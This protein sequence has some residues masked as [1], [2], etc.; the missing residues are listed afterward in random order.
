MDQEAAPK[1]LELFVYGRQ[2]F[3]EDKQDNLWSIKIVYL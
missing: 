1:R 3:L 2:V